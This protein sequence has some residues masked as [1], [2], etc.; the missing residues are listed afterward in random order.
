MPDFDVAATGLAVPPS[1]APVTSYFPAVAV[2]NLGIEPAPVTGILRI[3]DRAAGTLIAT[4]NLTPATIPVDATV[5]VASPVPWQPTAGDIGKHFLF[6]ATI[7]YTKDQNLANNNLSPVDILVTAEPPPPPPPVAAHASQHEH[8][9]ADE[10]NLDD[11]P[12]KLSESQTPTEHA[13]NHEDGGTDQ[14]DVEGLTGLLATAQTP[15]THHTTHEPGGADPVSGITPAAHATSHEPAGTDPIPNVQYKTEKSQAN[16]YPSLDQNGLVPVDELGSNVPSADQFLRANQTW[17]APPVLVHASDKHDSTVEAT[18]NKGTANGYAGLNANAQLYDVT[19]D[20]R[21]YRI[22]ST[23]ET[24]R[25]G[26]A[27]A[28]GTNMYGASYPIGTGNIV[29][30]EAHGYLGPLTPGDWSVELYADIT[31]A[32]GNT[33]TS[34]SIILTAGPNPNETKFFYLRFSAELTDDA[35]GTFHFYAKSADAVPYTLVSSRITRRA[36]HL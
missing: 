36:P 27:S 1:P 13:S 31:I 15:A 9:G 14:L 2:A 17:D 16:G 12:G 23:D 6:T 25:T 35:S 29:I 19:P 18:A 34:P 21:C 7:Y 10:L 4:H 11:L 28:G 33:L 32:P 22:D 8:G 20:W 5:N 30:I 3:Y 26:T 24:S